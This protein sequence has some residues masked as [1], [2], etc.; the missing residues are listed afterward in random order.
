MV[1]IQALTKAIYVTIFLGKLSMSL[2]TL[3]N[4]WMQQNVILEVYL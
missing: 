2:S 1:F 4:K 3:V